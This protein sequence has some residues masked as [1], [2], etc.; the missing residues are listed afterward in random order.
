MTDYDYFIISYF[1]LP[2]AAF[3][4]LFIIGWKI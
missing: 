3:I 2:L 1:T 4:T